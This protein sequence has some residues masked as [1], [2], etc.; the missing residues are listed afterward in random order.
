MT[1]DNKIRPKEI[2][3]CLGIT[4]DIMASGHNIA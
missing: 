3:K 4:D 2:L 1:S